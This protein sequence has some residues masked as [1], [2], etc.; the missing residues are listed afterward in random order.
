MTHYPPDRKP[1]VVVIGAGILGCSLAAQLASRSVRVTLIDNAEPGSGA[2][3]HSFAWLNA[4]AGK[5]PDYYQAFNRRSLDAWPRFE[6][7][8]RTNIELHWGGELRWTATS[9]EDN[10][11]TQDFQTQNRSGYDYRL[12]TQEQFHALEPDIQAHDFRSAGYSPT[13]GTVEP[14]RIVQACLQRI[15]E[16]GG[17][18]L[19]HTEVLSFDRQKYETQKATVLS[20]ETTEGNLVADT[21][22][23]AA[24]TGSSALGR[25]FDVVLP[26]KESPGVIVETTPVNRLF[27]TIDVLNTPLISDTNTGL[28]LRQWSDG[29]VMIGE[30]TQE[31]YATDNSLAHGLDLL[32][33]ATSHLPSL[34][35]ARI[36]KVTLGHRPMPADGLPVLGFFPTMPSLYVTL[37]HSGITLAP[38]ISELAATEILTGIRVKELQPYRPERFLSR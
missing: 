14:L 37:A 28:H 12:L 16:G 32:D 3:G 1:H 20:I 27:R 7:F 18:L 15:H 35:S 33:R 23:I 38:V 24:G 5:G 13:E 19:A 31:Y 29:T 8:L 17:T 25:L 9:Q 6:R 21:V 11:L 30:G 10:Q 34:R 26:Q 4:T 22:V 2:T 36:S